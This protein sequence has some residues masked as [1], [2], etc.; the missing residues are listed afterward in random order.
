MAVSLVLLSG[1]GSV[2]LPSLEGLWYAAGINLS[3]VQLGSANKVALLPKEKAQSLDL[4]HQYIDETESESQ[5][6]H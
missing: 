2:A 6:C 1:G 5:R 4:D 3:V